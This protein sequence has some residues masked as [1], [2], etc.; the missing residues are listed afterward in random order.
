[1][2]GVGIQESS[3][4]ILV[5]N[6]DEYYSYSTLSGLSKTSDQPVESHDPWVLAEKAI[7]RMVERG[8]TMRSD[9]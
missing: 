6:C 8:D 5:Q 7:G 4:D 2:I 3:S 9:R 1:M